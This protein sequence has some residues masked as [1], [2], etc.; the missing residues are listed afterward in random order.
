[1]LKKEILTKQARKNGHGVH[2]ILKYQWG[3]SGLTLQLQTECAKLKICCNINNLR[4]CCFPG[5]P[6]VYCLCTVNKNRQI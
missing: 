4:T 6:I 3:I 5:L 2:A 1:M